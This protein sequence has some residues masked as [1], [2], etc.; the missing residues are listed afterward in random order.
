MTEMSEEEMSVNTRNW[1]NLVEERDF[2]DTCCDYSIQPPGFICHNA[3]YAN[4]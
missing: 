3:N 2:L 1:I 4:L